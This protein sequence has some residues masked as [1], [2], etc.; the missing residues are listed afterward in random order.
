MVLEAL[1]TQ[2]S[3][4]IDLRPR[5]LTH[6]VVLG[7]TGHKAAFFVVGSGRVGVT[8]ILSAMGREPGL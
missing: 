8:C 4:G 7:V 6:L 3:H 2:T 1:P 5:E